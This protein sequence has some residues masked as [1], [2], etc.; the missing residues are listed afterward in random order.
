MIKRKLFRSPGL[1]EEMTKPDDKYRPSTIIKIRLDDTPIMESKDVD[2]SDSDEYKNLIKR[3]ALLRLLS[4]SRS[5]T[6]A[7]LEKYAIIEMD[8]HNSELV[9]D[10]ATAAEK[11]SVLHCIQESSNGNILVQFFQHKYEGDDLVT[12]FIGHDKPKIFFRNKT[13]K[14]SEVLDYDVTGY[15]FPFKNPNH[16]GLTVYD[17]FGIQN[18]FTNKKKEDTYEGDE[19]LIMLLPFAMQFIHDYRR[20]RFSPISQMNYV[21]VCYIDIERS[22]Y[23]LIKD[24]C[25]QEAYYEVA[26]MNFPKY[27]D[28]YD[29]NPSPRKLTPHQECINLMNIVN[30]TPEVLTIYFNRVADLIQK[31]KSGDRYLPYPLKDVNPAELMEDLSDLFNKYFPESMVIWEV[32]ATIADRVSKE[33]NWK[34]DNE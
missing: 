3:A 33:K 17:E 11:R 4:I 2:A 32:A 24:K 25:Q 9:K 12:R 30:E 13:L 28:P 21:H 16:R 23:A 31:V 10:Y 20:C 27:C 19:D 26:G 15:F 29:E 18:P 7:V 5:V 22:L 34:G 1:F 14:F 8:I 6:M